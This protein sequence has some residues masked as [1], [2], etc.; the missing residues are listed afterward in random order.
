MTD[1]YDMIYPQSHQPGAWAHAQN[2]G[3]SKFYS[4]YYLQKAMSLVS[5]SGIPEN[6]DE[7]YLKYC[8]FALGHVEVVNVP[9]YGVIPQKGM[10]YG[11]NVYYQPSKMQFVN[12]LYPAMDRTINKDCTVIRLQPNW[13]GV[14]PICTMFA[15][16]MALLVENFACNSITSKLAYVFAT[17]KENIA[18]SFKLMFSKIANGEPAV[19]V[20]KKMMTEDGKPAW[21]AFSNNI[22]NNYIV[23]EILQNMEKVDQMFSAYI[24]IP[25][26]NDKKERM[27]SDE[28][29]T[30]NIESMCKAA[31]WME[32]I[33]AGLEKTNSMFG[34]SVRA[35]WR[36]DSMLNG[37]ES[38]SD[39]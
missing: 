9:G 19:A 37:G 16:M 33:N 4:R 32:T 35:D 17:D 6:W 26:N 38:T 7:T 23:T 24:G 2:S 13:Q 22:K 39:R 28:V 8:L 34:T 21:T 1:P 3:L 18:E 25:A 12:P 14:L 11:Y 31:L 15:D 10:P 20:G 36:I 5:F 30:N 27:I 29:E